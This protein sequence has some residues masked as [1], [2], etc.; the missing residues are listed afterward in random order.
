MKI[1]KKTPLLTAPTF[2]EEWQ[3]SIFQYKEG[4]I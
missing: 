4:E 2:R 1:E 3:N